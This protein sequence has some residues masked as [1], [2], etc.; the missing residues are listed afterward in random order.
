MLNRRDL[1]KKIGVSMA[2]AGTVGIS[3]F[4]ARAARI[5]RKNTKMHVCGDYHG[6]VG[7][8]KADMVTKANLEYNLRHG[9]RH[10]TLR[11]RSWHGAWDLDEMK[12]WKDSCDKYGIML[13]AIRMEDDYIR[14]KKGLDRDRMI[15]TIQENIRK[16]ASVGIQVITYHWRM[17]PIRRNRKKT[18]RGGVTYLGFKLEKDWQDLRVGKAG[19]VDSDEYWQRLDYFLQN[20]IPVAR[21]YKVKMACHPYDPP[22]LPFGYQGVE[23]WDS[24]S[25]FDAIKRYESLFESPYNGFQI[26]LGTLAEGLKNPG[27]EVLPIVEYLAKRGK[28]HDIHMRNIQG[29]LNDF[30]EVFPDE[31]EMDFLEIIRILRDYQYPGA[32]TP[33]HM[34][35]HPDDPDK[36]QAYAF[37]FG[38]IKA[39]IH[40]AN[41]E[42]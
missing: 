26:C 31:G 19:K 14:M 23:N 32:I 4:S 30:Y 38:Y 10:L 9:I 17:I 42:V 7:G 33:D 39:L 5:P 37:G 12:R 11:K 21:Q 6:V 2:V 27:K 1:G 15:E 28:I 36:L 40:A 25:V 34:P 18:G 29:G 13:E 41:S 8:K 24:P 3:P 16:A 35:A 20:I 22:G